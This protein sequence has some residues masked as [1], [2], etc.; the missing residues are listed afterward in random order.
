VAAGTSGDASV[1]LGGAISIQIW[2]KSVGL[3]M[4]GDA[5]VL[6]GQ[7]T[8]LGMLIYNVEKGLCHARRM[9]RVNL[10]RTR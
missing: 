10:D 1:L 4:S 2:E 6:R 7:G 3:T 5:M 8:T 9:S